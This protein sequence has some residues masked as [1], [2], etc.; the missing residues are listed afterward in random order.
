[1]SLYAELGRF[2]SYSSAFMV[3]GTDRTVYGGKNSAIL[4]NNL[5]RCLECSQLES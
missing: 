2:G 1:M 4:T 5:D 3:K